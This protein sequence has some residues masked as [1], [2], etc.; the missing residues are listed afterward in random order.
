MTQFPHTDSYVTLNMDKRN[1]KIRDMMTSSNG[2]I[3]SVTGLLWEDFTGDRWI[4]LTKTVTRSFDGFF[5][6]RLNKRLSKLSGRRS[7]ETIVVLYMTSK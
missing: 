2:N 6:L 4:P 3:F 7:F 1:T 5:D